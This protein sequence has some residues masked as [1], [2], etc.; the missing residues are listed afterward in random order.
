MCIEVLNNSIKRN[1]YSK[2]SKTEDILGCSFKEFK[3]HI[4]SQWE[5]WMSWG[6]HGKY[7]GDLN[8]GWDLDHIKPLI[9]SENEEDMIKLN[10]HTNF[11]PLCG[12]INRYVK[13]DNY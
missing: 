5:D 8:Y 2:K 6:N 10:H 11:Q 3:E 9:L 13:K 4:E 7:N 1:G 12:Y